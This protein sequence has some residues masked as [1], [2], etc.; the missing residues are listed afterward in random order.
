MRL[1]TPASSINISP[2]TVFS[3][4]FLKPGTNK[5]VTTFRRQGW[6]DEYA[7]IISAVSQNLFIRSL[8]A[9]SM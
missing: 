9:C 7:Q 2:L 4:G 6:S 5:S 1:A 3:V 8:V